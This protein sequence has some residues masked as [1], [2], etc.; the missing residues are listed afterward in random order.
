M[1]PWRCVLSRHCKHVAV[2][3]H[4]QPHWPSL[5][6][7]LARSWQLRL[8]RA[9]NEPHGRHHLAFSESQ[10]AAVLGSPPTFPNWTDLLSL[11]R[12]DRLDFFNHRHRLFFFLE[13][14]LLFS[15]K[16]M[17]ASQPLVILVLDTSTMG[18]DE[19]LARRAHM[20][21]LL[22]GP[23]A[24]GGR[25]LSLRDALRHTAEAIKAVCE[26]LF[27]AEDRDK[28]VD[29]G[30]V[31][32][33]FFTLMVWQ[34]L[35]AFVG[36]SKGHPSPVLTLRSNQFLSPAAVSL[37]RRSQ[38]RAQEHRG[39][40]GS[41]V[42]RVPLHH[43]SQGAPGRPGTPDRRLR[44]GAPRCAAAEDPPSSS[45][46]RGPARVSAQRGNARSKRSGPSSRVSSCWAVFKSGGPRG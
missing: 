40:A 32:Q 29:P 36:K 19:H 8:A 18:S 17:A 27:C 22:T 14:F 26:T 5:P 30:V 3:P 34:H 41:G 37:A 43:E 10:L 16:K 35:F 9:Q 21:R 12:L 42:R 15:R 38:A 23:I 45:G 4:S 25:A 1:T 28:R 39:L 46:D 24:Q 2:V 20:A 11:P 33:E 31:G 7:G 44:R 13:T 6:G